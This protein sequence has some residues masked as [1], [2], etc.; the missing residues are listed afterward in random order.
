MR[1]APAPAVPRIAI[2]LAVAGISG[3]T[4]AAPAPCDLTLAAT[5]STFPA[6]GQR[7]RVRIPASSP[8]MQLRAS[9]GTSGAPVSAGVGSM[10]AEFVADADSPPLVI[11]AAVGGSYCGFSILRVGLAPDAV[12]PSPVTLVVIDPATVAGDADTEVRVYVFAV[13]VHGVPRRGKAPAFVPAAGAISGIEPLG[14]GVWRARWKVPAGNADE[15]RIEVAFGSEAPVTASL[16]R[17]GGRPAALEI[18]EDQASKTNGIPGA[19]IVRIRDS[20]GNLTDG[21][22]EVSSN[23]ATVE[24]PVHLE[25]GVY[26]ASLVVPGE[27][28]GKSFDVVATIGGIFATATLVVPS[29]PAAKVTIEPHEPILADGSSPG[30]L[31]VLPVTVSDAHGNPVNDVPVGSAELG[32]FLEAL[33]VGPGS[34]SLPYRPPRVLEDT[35]DHITVR[36]GTVSTHAD[37]QLLG[38]GFSGSIGLKAGMVVSGSVGPT[39]GVEG[40]A[41]ASF[42]HTQLGLTLDLGWWTRSQSSTTTAGG[43]TSSYYAR[44]NYLPILLSL[45]WRKLFAS[46]WLLWASGGGGIAL[47]WNRSQVSGQ[48]SVSEGGLAPAAAISVSAG[49]RLGPGW[50]FLDLGVTWIGNAKLSTL[51]GSSVNFLLLL[52]Y[53]FDVV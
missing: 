37:L 19:V 35:V 24:A 42:G 16:I 2:V 10:R 38:G 6:G 48:A 9:S 39:V 12:A 34:W 50:L 17:K 32:E 22:V 13:D 36:A 8:A 4:E 33:V 18:E 28:G 40:S 25:R 31:V 5:P 21:A 1:R 3:A 52:G 51:S 27:M 26:R 45:A 41:W 23:A 29:A 30:R 49:P 14:L 53:R 47:V 46:H 7:V 20:A 43:V 11:L 44:Q 15:T